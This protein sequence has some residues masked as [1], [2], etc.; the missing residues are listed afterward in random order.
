MGTD[1]KI[2][3]ITLSVNDTKIDSDQGYYSFTIVY[4]FAMNFSL[5]V[6]YFMNV[7]LVLV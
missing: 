1:L 4:R 6:V 2:N 3:T 7:F 5:V